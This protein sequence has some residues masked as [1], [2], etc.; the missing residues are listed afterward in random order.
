MKEEQLSEIVEPLLSWYAAHARVL[1]WRDN[2]T[3]YRVWV[4]EIMLQQ[5]RVEAVKPYFERFMRELPD[6]AALAE[7]DWPQLLKLWEGLG[8]Y[9]RVRNLQEAARIV[10]REHNGRLPAAYTELIKLPGIGRYTAGAIASIAYGALEPAVDGNVLRVM[11]RLL[12]S[13]ENVSDSKVKHR[14]ADALK[15]VLPPGQAGDFNQALME[16]GATICL[17]N[18]MPHCDLCP[19]E[20]RCA[21]HMQGIA[22]DLP[23]K[24]AKR[25][26]RIEERTVFLILCGGKIALRK[27]PNK[28]LLAGLWELPNVEGTLTPEDA[29]TVLAEWDLSCAQMEPLP[30]AKHIFTHIEWRMSGYRI[31]VETGP[32]AHGFR[33]VSRRELQEEIALPSAFKTYI[34]LIDNK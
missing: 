4:S 14:M 22:T 31:W 20:S 15:Q 18:G 1:P 23:V 10:M 21:A 13:P 24:S 8:Y 34:G 17:P 19:L 12:A 27:R 3:P 9:N 30:E 26:R 33:W 25:I 32:P 29:T 16:L 7:A 2:P 11:A 6:V 5:T 28:G